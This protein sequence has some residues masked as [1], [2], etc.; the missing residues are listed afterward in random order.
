MGCE[1]APF[2]TPFKRI[3]VWL[4]RVH[5]GLKLLPQEQQGERRTLVDVVKMVEDKL[6]SILDNII[7]TG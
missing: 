2:L 5:K 4:R 6:R 7:T 1:L 3:L